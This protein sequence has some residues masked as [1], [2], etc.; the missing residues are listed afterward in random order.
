M[1]RASSTSSTTEQERDLLDAA[2]MSAAD[3]PV[4]QRHAACEAVSVR[5]FGRLHLG[6]LDPSATL[7]RAFGSLGV[8]VD[9]FSTAL[10]IRSASSDQW[11]AQHEAARAEL[12]RAAAFVARLRE[13][14]GRREALALHLWEVLPAHS[15]FGSG[16]QLALA[17]GRAFAR[18]QAIEVSS[19]TLAQW[20]GRGA[21]SGIGIGGFDTGG[22]LVDGGPSA[23]GEPARLIARLDVPAAWRV[24]VVQDQRR[25]GLSGAA[26]RD[27]IA[28]LAPLARAQAAE[29]CHQV[30]MRVLPG[31]AGDDFAAFAAGLTRMQALLGEHFAPAQEGSA[32]SSPDVRTLMQWLQRAA[33]DGIAIGQSSWGPTG[34]A[35][36][37]SADCAAALIERARAAGAVAPGL[38]V[39]TMAA[40]NQGAEITARG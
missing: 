18:W 9:G 27:A 23:H 31:T 19:A 10:E 6:F 11:H 35:F 22:L 15:G 16:T 38:Q 33:G 8:V 37:P 17:V 4:T 24:I 12:D 21:R 30:L 2:P 25:R 7:G 29:V 14:T 39:A 32:W 1:I 40:R 26:E 3:L 5:A 20:L 28:R 36:V 34:F 13:H